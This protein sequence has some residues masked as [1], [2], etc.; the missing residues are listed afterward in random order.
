MRLQINNFAKIG[1]SDIILDGI[2]IIAGENNTGKSTVGKILFSL[3]NALCDIEDKVRKERL[4]EIRNTTFT[5]L[6][7]NISGLDISRNTLTRNSLRLS[8]QIRQQIKETFEENSE[9]TKQD[10]LEMVEDEL[11][12]W[13]D[14]RAGMTHYEWDGLV[15]QLTQNISEILELSEKDIIREVIT[16]YFGNV[17]HDQ[18]SSLVNKDNAATLLRL[19]IKGR[20]N[21]VVFEENRCKEFESEI[22]L[23]N[24]AIYIDNP[25]IID[26]LASSS[27]MNPM[28]KLLKELLADTED[29]E[30]MDGI[31]ETL[32]A[33]EKL[34]DIYDALARVVDGNIE[35]NKVDDEFYLKSD[36][37]E[38]P[39][40]FHNLSAGMKSFVVLKMLVEK[41]CIKEKDV[42]ILDEPEIHLH[43]QWQVAYAELIVLLQK[44]FD[45]N[46][47]VTTHSPYFVDAI[48]LFSC[49]YDI[50]KKVNYYLSTNMG[51]VA[52]MENV[53]DHIDAIYKKMASPIQILDTLRYELNNS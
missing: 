47:V 29:T 37:F 44:H 32:R 42:I 19:E 39:L 21:T 33:K 8:R 4:A 35:R 28:N 43:P 11:N 13:D 10:I 16:G 7:N 31:I 3:F 52:K 51:A 6:Q 25:F 50:D 22:D 34:S 40:S 48:N 14:L 38:E 36:C 20:N 2:T 53:T 18:I 15:E 30:A 49:K 46:I 23:T 9:I 27:L 45:L 24:K 12:V 17:F 41:G 26:E 5:I 1:Q